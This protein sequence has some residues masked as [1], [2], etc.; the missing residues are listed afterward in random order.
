MAF[1]LTGTVLGVPDFM[2]EKTFGGDGADYGRAIIETSDGDIVIA[3]RIDLPWPSD[4][5]VYLVKVKSNGEV[6]WEKNLGSNTKHVEAYDVVEAAD[7]G[8]VMAGVYE[9][10]ASSQ[11]YLMKTDKDGV[12]QW[13]K[14]YGG[15]ASEVGYSI[16]NTDDGGY[17][18]TGYT[19]S[20][21]DSLDVYLVKT[22]SQGDLLWERAYTR[23][24]EN[25]KGHSVI[26]SDDGDYMVFGQVY[27]TGWGWD[28]Y[29]V[30]VEPNGDEA[31]RKVYGNIRAD[32]GYSIAQTGDGGYLLAGYTF[33]DD[34][35]GGDAYLV[36]VD[37]GGNVLW[38]E[39]YGDV[40]KDRVW[41][42]TETSDGH[43]L[44]GG[45]RDDQ[46]FMMKIEA[47]GSEVW[48]KVYDQE[49]TYH[50]QVAVYNSDNEY[51]LVGS[52]NVGDSDVLLLKSGEPEPPAPAEPKPEPNPGVI[53]WGRGASPGG[54]VRF[55]FGLR[56][57]NWTDVD[58]PLIDL[59]VSDNLG[60]VV[61]NRRCRVR[62][63]HNWYVWH[64]SQDM[65]PSGS[66]EARVTAGDW[67]RSK[68]VTVP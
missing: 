23:D 5:D 24:G 33:Q 66:Y 47:D 18:I 7:G 14:T 58:D 20:Y 44:M 12:M 21:G 17:I 61:Y 57:I 25:D 56:D 36:K 53:F 46:C 48:S 19:T 60:E 6:I 37:D 9:P 2:W 3:G 34:P 10:G 67:T 27:V 32:A 31:W 59:T 65:F 54:C 41:S 39:I 16:A 63:S 64:L 35:A 8:Y 22:D 15:L 30:N 45:T 29:L 4:P 49:A 11:L 51:Y 43:Y 42:I 38:E 40:G 28:Y 52:R 55:H 62:R 13:E 1:M 50:K 26:Q 68:P